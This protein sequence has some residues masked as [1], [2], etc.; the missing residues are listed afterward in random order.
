[1]ILHFLEKN[2]KYTVYLPLVIYWLALLTAT[3]L[4]SESLPKISY[5]DKTM[6]FLAYGGLGFLLTLTFMVQ[7]KFPEL[8][9]Y[10]VLA[11]ITVAALYGAL[12]EFHQS[13]IPGRSSEMLDWMADF[14]GSIMGAYL[15]LAVLKIPVRQRAD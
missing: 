11:A 9:G 6:H 3:S 13:F 7:S 5:N 12:D 10:A 14:I 1:M 2:K 8:R 15:C 4:P